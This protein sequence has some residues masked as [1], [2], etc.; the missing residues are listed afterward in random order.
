LGQGRL[1]A[2]AGLPSFS[3]AIAGMRVIDQLVSPGGAR[4]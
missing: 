4:L 3:D 2:E 1:F